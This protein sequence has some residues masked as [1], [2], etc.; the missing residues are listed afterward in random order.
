MSNY[1]EYMKKKK[2][3]SNGLDWVSNRDKID[4]QDGRNYVHVVSIDEKCLQ[5]C[6]QS[7]AGA[8]NYHSADKDFKWHIQRSIKYHFNSIIDRAIEYAEKDVKDAGILAREDIE[9][10][11]EEINTNQEDK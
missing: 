11:L 8:N 6:G 1:S 4:S 9:S 5:F 2:I 7:S 10:M 3:L